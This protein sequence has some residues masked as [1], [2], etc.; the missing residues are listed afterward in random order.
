MALFESDQNRL[1]SPR[2]SHWLESSQTSLP[3]FSW[4]EPKNVHQIVNY[5][6]KYLKAFSSTLK[7][8]TDKRETESKSTIA[9]VGEV[10]HRTVAKHFRQDLLDCG[11]LVPEAF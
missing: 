4:K 11:G 5:F 3:L 6:S 7:R 10:D 1:K 8:A 9:H 2:F